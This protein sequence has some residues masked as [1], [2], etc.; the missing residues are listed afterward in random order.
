[1]RRAFSIPITARM[2]LLLACDG[3]IVFFL[4]IGRELSQG[5]YVFILERKRH[6]VEWISRE[7]LSQLDQRGG[8]WE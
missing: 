5:D 7:R 8:T 2:R 4:R 1:M 6:R 3:L